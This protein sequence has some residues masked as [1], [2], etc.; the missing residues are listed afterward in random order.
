MT[1]PLSLQAASI[2]VQQEGSIRAEADFA[3]LITAGPAAGFLANGD[4]RI[5]AGR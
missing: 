3:E 2:L 5:P 1:T 4:D